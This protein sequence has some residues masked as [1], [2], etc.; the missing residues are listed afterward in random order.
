MKND[1]AEGPR[2]WRWAVG[3]GAVVVVLLA[4]VALRPPEG[5]RVSVARAAR[6]SLVVPVLCDGSLEPPPGGEVRAPEP[7]VVATVA[8]RDGERVSRGTVLV[9]LDDPDLMQSALQARAAALQLSEDHARASADVEEARRVAEHAHEMAEA[10]ARL[11]A[12]SA[13]SRE[14]AQTDKLADRQAQDRLRAAQA[15]LDAIAGEG[16]ASR[17]ALA[18]EEARRLEERIAALTL[19]APLDGV[20]YG[21][22]R[23]IG[24]TVAAGQ[25]VASI[26]DPLHLRVRARVDQPDLP[27]IQVGQ[28][29][30]VSFD[31]LPD[32]RW[33]GRVLSVSA[34]VRETGGREIG[35]VVG[36]ITDPNLKLPP[37]AS[38]N[39]QVVVGERHGVLT[40][41]RAAVMRDGDRRYVYRMEDGR[42]RRR[43]VSIGLVGLNDVEVASGLAENDRV[44]LPGSAALTDGMRVST[45]KHE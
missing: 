32:R 28:R 26:A 34:G 11:L 8:A 7:A 6:S 19:R 29:F 12:Q 24:E 14:A 9:R 44:I 27:R 35:E 21:L 33:E 16:H 4:A 2:V 22:P 42:A 1:Q 5:A 13:I 45:A 10:D 25:L 23:K 40:V 15:R 3:V 17:L 36:E 20:A 41:P 30:L 18:Q 39:V 37:N 38:V 43:D 31:G